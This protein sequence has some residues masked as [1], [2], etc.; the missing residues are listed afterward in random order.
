[1]CVCSAAGGLATTTVWGLDLGGFVLGSNANH[2]SSSSLGT[3]FLA[4]PFVNALTGAQDI[5]AVAAP[6][7]LTGT[8]SAVNTFFLYGAE[9]NLRRN[10]FCGCNWYIDGFVGWRCWV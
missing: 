3:P 5:E 4:R 7:G 1:M 10:L 8:F 2:F 6:N 9:A